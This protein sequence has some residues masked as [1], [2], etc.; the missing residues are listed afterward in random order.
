MQNL[1]SL[2]SPALF[3]PLLLHPH[4]LTR[5]YPHTRA[6]SHTYIL[7]HS[8]MHTHTLSHTH[9]LAHSHSHTLTHSRT[10]TNAHIHTRLIKLS[11]ERNE[12]THSSG[13]M[14]L[15]AQQ[16][17]ELISRHFESQPGDMFCRKLIGNFRFRQTSAEQWLQK[18]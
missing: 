1:P 10:L 9:T 8:Q 14:T 12:G 5:T 7:T 18:N 11:F 17:E 15:E 4:M 16:E 6:H 13:V 3:L 2:L